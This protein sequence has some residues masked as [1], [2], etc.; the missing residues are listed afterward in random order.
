MLSDWQKTAASRRHRNTPCSNS[1]PQQGIQ[2]LSACPLHVVVQSRLEVCP[3]NGKASKLQT[4]ITWRPRLYA[5]T[6]EYMKKKCIAITVL[7]LSSTTYEFHDLGT[8]WQFVQWDPQ[9]GKAKHKD[10]EIISITS[11]CM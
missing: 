9:K 6:W 10:A 1:L 11:V 7:C 8:D 5:C 3:I 2:A 4:Q